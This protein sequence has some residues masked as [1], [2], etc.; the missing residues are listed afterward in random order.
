MLTGGPG[1]GPDGCWARQL[2]ADGWAADAVEADHRLHSLNHPDAPTLA[3]GA[4]PP[5]M[6]HLADQEYT[7][8]SRSKRQ[9]VDTAMQ[10]LAQRL[11]PMR[12]Y[13]AEQRDR[14]AEHLTDAIGFLA[15]GLYI[16]DAAPLRDHLA[17]T[18]AV[19]QAQQV[20]TD[21]LTLA[22]DALSAQLREFPRALPSTRSASAPKDRTT[23]EPA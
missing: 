15:A 22:L 20:P 6:P 23:E 2:G 3:P 11:S 4:V 17:W 14:T 5:G 8:I 19:L 21:V 1:F 18:T 12:Q 9:I 13:S 10:R 16:D 7:L